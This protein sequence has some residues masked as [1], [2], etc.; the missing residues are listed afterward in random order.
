MAK[1]IGKF[2]DWPFKVP[3]IKSIIKKINAFTEA[4]KAARSGEEAYKYLKEG[5]SL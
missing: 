5:R 3:H 1:D 4:F 2:E